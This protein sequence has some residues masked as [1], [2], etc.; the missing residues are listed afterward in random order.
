M[1][2]YPL[3]A[4]TRAAMRRIQVEV[5]IERARADAAKFGLSLNC[6]DRLYRYGTHPA[7]EPGCR[8]DGTGCLCVCHDQQPLE[9]RETE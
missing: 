1:A 6:S 7:G 9:P 8:N 2:N 3:D 5:A 4:A